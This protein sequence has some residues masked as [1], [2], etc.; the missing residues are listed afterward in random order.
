[1]HPSRPG[2]KL[3]GMRALEGSSSAAGWG[4]RRAACGSRRAAGDRGTSPAGLA[5]VP[6]PETAEGFTDEGE[7]AL[8]ALAGMEDAAAATADVTN[9]E[10]EEEG[11]LFCVEEL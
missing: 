10:I 2:L 9:E 7:T 1:M 11:S 6:P 3:H 5:G 8:L 4:G